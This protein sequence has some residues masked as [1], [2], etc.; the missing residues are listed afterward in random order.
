MVSSSLPRRPLS[1][2]PLVGHVAVFYS[3]RPPIL[4]DLLIQQCG[5]SVLGKVKFHL[6]W[7]SASLSVLSLPTDDRHAFARGPILNGDGAM[8]Y[9]SDGKMVGVDGVGAVGSEELHLI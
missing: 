7:P 9:W 2:C 1:A 6:L 3:P 8:G 4:Q 5:L